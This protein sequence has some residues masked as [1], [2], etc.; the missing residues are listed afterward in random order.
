MK[1]RYTVVPVDDKW[2]VMS[3]F[4]QNICAIFATKH[5]AEWSANH[6]NELEEAVD[7]GM[8]EL[9]KLVKKWTKESI[10]ES[11]ILGE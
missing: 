9:L 3:R 1:A 11:E 5:E 8:K 2:G 10:I 7:G 6:L 4:T